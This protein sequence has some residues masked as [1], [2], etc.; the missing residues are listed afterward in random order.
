ML[1]A[2]VEGLRHLFLLLQPLGN[3]IDLLIHAVLLMSERFGRGTENL[4][5]FLIESVWA[6]FLAFIKRVCREGGLRNARCLTLIR[7]RSHPK[8]GF[9][10][11][12]YFCRRN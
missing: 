1:S 4:V 6:H 10:L 3:P 11:K 9:V 2:Q 5:D 8:S 12:F 7:K